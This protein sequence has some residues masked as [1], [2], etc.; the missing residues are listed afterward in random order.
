MF[1]DTA[2]FA[3]IQDK[4]EK[5]V[6]FALT[7]KNLKKDLPGCCYVKENNKKV[8]AYLAKDTYKFYLSEF[9]EECNK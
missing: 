1:V 5:P 8:K 2:T 4:N 9:K 6:S 7:K 3:F